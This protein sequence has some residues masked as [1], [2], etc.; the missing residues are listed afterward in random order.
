MCHGAAAAEEEKGDHLAPPRN[1]LLL[2]GQT[3]NWQR[4]ARADAN[5]KKTGPF[6]VGSKNGGFPL[7][8]AYF[9]VALKIARF[10]IVSETTSSFPHARKRATKKTSNRRLID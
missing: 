2:P 9:I 10:N 4:S 3:P 1:L 5:A 6:P 7:V 8:F